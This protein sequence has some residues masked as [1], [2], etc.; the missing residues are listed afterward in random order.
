M[1]LNQNPGNHKAIPHVTRDTL[2]KMAS[3]S[4]KATSLLEEIIEDMMAAQPTKIGYPSETSQSNFYPGNEK[5][6]KE[7]IE[8]ITK[9][10]KARGI[11]SETT[12][13]QKLPRTGS[14]ESDKFYV[15]RASAKKDPSPKLIGEVTIGDQQPAEVFLCRGDHFNELEQVDRELNQAHQYA[16]NPEQ[17]QRIVQLLEFLQSGSYRAFNDSSKT[18]LKDK[19]PRVEN[20][21]GWFTRYRDPSGTRDDIQSFVGIADAK[22]TERITKIAQGSSKIL[23]ELPWVT[24]EANNDKGS[25]EHA[26]MDIPSFSILHSKSIIYQSLSMP[27]AGLNLLIF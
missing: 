13:L 3:I 21:F 15:L 17:A 9:M 22:E 26:E 6:T 23:S 16:S 11:A 10:I 4:V 12:R 24:P 19:D 2:T 20:T 27:V 5:M 1:Q 18:W 25:F 14:E 7:E 8:I